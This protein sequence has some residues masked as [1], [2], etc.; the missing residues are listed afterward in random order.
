MSYF[1]EDIDIE[2]YVEE[3][4]TTDTPY[5]TEEI[6]LVAPRIL[7]G[8]EDRVHYVAETG[9]GMLA[10]TAEGEFGKKLRKAALVARTDEERFRDNLIRAAQTLDLQR[11]QVD[12]ILRWIPAIPDVRFK[13]PIGVLLGSMAAKYVRVGTK[14]TAEEKSALDRIFALASKV[15]ETRINE[16]DVI[17]YAAL[18]NRITRK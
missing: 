8:Q 3:P 9:Y 17:R 6:K 7:P 4:D 16:F 11:G 18:W 13:S 1:E 10:T 14:L 12:S 2:D 5:E 15:Q